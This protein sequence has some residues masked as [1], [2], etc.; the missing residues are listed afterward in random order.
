MP[1]FGRGSCKSNSEVMYLKTSPFVE[2]IIASFIL[3][4][5]T[6]LNFNNSHCHKESQQSNWK[7]PEPF[8]GAGL[9][10]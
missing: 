8:S 7:I 2:I 4:I 10:M 6:E 3:A 1:V 5:Q 9:F